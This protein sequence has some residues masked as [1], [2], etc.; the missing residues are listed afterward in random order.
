M[1]VKVRL[2]AKLKEKY[3]FECKEMEVNSIEEL[4]SKFEGVALI[5]LNGELL[6]SKDVKLRD[7]DTVDLMPPFSGG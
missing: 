6:T 2:F 7:G 3:G 1:K 5:A 4:L